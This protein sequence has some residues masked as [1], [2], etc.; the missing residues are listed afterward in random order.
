MGR[1]INYSYH[2]V[3]IPYLGKLHLFHIIDND[4]PLPEEGIIEMPFLNAFDRYIISK[5]FLYIDNKKLP[6]YEDGTFISGNTT[7]LPSKKA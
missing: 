7:Q 2:A 4:F 5:D 1:D 3:K 6:L